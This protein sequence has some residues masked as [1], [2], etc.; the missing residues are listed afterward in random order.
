MHAFSLT[1]FSP[2]RIKGGEETQEQR[3]QTQRVQ[4]RWEC[5]LHNNRCQPYIWITTLSRGIITYGIQQNYLAKRKSMQHS[6]LTYH[7]MKALGISGNNSQLHR[8]VHKRL[9]TR[10]FLLFP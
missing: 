10:V 2:G 5:H 3:S 1:A 7:M 9:T 8:L 6:L 4:C